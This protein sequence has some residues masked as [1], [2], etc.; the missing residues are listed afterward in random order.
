[1]EVT[2]VV[3]RSFGQYSV[4]DQILEPADIT[5]VLASEHAHSVVAVKSPPKAAQE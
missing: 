1:M 5:S 3:T 4:G 2:L